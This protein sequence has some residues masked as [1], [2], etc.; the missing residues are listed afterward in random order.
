MKDF[1]VIVNS[2]DKY[3]DTWFPF[4]KLLKTYWPG[5]DDYDIILN[6][7]TKEYNCDF[8]KLRTICGGTSAT[9]SQRL[10]NIL[11]QI[12][13]EFVLFFLDDYF[14]MSPV[15]TESLSEAVELIKSDEKIGYIGLKYNKTHK[16]RDPDAPLPQEHFFNRD[17]TDT[18]NRINCNTALW[19]KSWL[20]SLIKDHETPW[21]FEKYGSYRSRRTDKK[22]M[23]INNMNGIMA[24]VFNYDVEIKYGHG[25]TLGQWL[26]KNKEL[27]EKHGIVVDFDN[28]GFNYKIYEEAINPKPPVEKE[29]EKLTFREMLYN[30]K[31]LVRRTKKKLRKFIRRIRSLI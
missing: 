17:L 31:R 13:T 14:L 30:I 2:C 24:P 1:T 3:E 10:K 18:V 5:C 29:P 11:N 4:F 19:R 27:F 6:T 15:S 12:D 23:I 21:E 20:L 8:M 9:W 26:P 16:F 7:E 22:V 28:L 25:L